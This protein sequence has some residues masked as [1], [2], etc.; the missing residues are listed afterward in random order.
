MCMCSDLSNM[1]FNEYKCYT[2]SHQLTQGTRLFLKDHSTDIR[3]EEKQPLHFPPREFLLQF[4]SKQSGIS[5]AYPPFMVY[6]LKRWPITV[7]LT[8]E[9][10]V[11]LHHILMVLTPT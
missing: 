5:S 8:S 10:V 2:R 6:T 7:A 11:Q 9:V 4:S 3:K 1:W